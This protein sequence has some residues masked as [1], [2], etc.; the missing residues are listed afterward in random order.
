[1]VSNKPSNSAAQFSF[2]YKVSGIEVLPD[3]VNQT[4]KIS[5]TIFNVVI[6]GSVTHSQR[7]W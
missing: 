1:M 6:E 2:K 4:E 5:R 7:I 3:S